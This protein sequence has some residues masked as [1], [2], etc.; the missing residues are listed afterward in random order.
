L[1]TLS[2]RDIHF[3]VDKNGEVAMSCGDPV[4]VQHAAAPA[5]STMMDGASTPAAFHR[6]PTL[7]SLAYL[8]LELF[9]DRTLEAVHASAQPTTATVLSSYFT[10][11]RVLEKA[12]F[13]SENYRSA[14]SRCL[15]GDLHKPGRGFESEDFCQA[16]YAGVIAL[17]E[18]DLEN[19]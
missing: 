2:S 12:T 11:Q 13:P 9:L 16:F 7:L 6:N 15:Q 1:D 18:K 14:I 3:F 17:L 4:L 10:A 8:L 19:A 5:T